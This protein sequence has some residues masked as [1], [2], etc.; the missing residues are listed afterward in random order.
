MEID[1]IISR[2]VCYREC[3]LCI[4]I[5][6]NAF[7]STFKSQVQK[8]IV[9]SRYLTI[10]ETNTIINEKI[11]LL[12][13]CWVLGQNKVVK[14]LFLHYN[15]LFYHETDPIY[16]FFIIHT[17]FM[18]PWT[19]PEMTTPFTLRVKFVMLTHWFFT[20]DGWKRQ[21]SNQWKTFITCHRRV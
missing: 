19:L 15:S 5:Y 9:T 7:E 11:L 14:H 8:T 18:Y 4:L 2:I 10:L 17:S 1:R 12:F 21:I 20:N 6:I 3:R 13:F 16:V